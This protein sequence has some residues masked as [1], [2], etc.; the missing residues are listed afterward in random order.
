MRLHRRATRAYSAA[1]PKTPPPFFF[2][3]R[4]KASSKRTSLAASRAHS[5]GSA[6]PLASATAMEDAELRRRL[7]EG[8]AGLEALLGGP[9][10]D[11][12]VIERPG[13]LASIVPS[14]PDSPALNAA[15][16]LDPEQAP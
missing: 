5:P 11:G 6:P 8:F 10:K 13:I 3:T 16:A 12:F 7:W 15:V 9:G 4:A 14:A 1:Q 2:T